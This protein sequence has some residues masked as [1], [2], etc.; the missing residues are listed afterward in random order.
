MPNLVKEKLDAYFK[1]EENSKNIFNQ[2]A[3]FIY[4][5]ESQ[6]SNSD[7]FL[8]ARLLPDEFLSKIIYYFDGDI[9]KIP[10]R[11]EYKDSY[12]L[13]LCFYLKEIKGWSWEEIKNFLPISE[14]NK[15]DDLS[16]ISIGKKI[17]TIKESMDRNL[18][19]S[20][21]SI[22]IDMTEFSNYFNK[23]CKS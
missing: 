17:N 3:L 9:I 23:E 15:N 22:S 12:I 11:Q 5:S 6:K 19:K 8:L 13:A 1:V 4:F 18:M 2:L 14:F 16:S 21:N 10:T 7:L 20:L